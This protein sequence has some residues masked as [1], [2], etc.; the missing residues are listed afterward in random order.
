[1]VRL[2]ALYTGVSIKREP[3]FMQKKIWVDYLRVLA[4]FAVVT[5]HVTAFAYS[6]FDKIPIDDWWL[7]NLLN[8]LSRFS[9]PMFVM[10]SGYLIL[11]KS[12]TTKE[13]YIKRG[14]RIIPA[15]IFW[16]VFFVVFDF[17]FGDK[18]ISASI[19]QL[20]KDFI[21]N[22]DTYFHLWYLTMLICL[23]MFV[24][25]I[26]NYI[27]GKQPST[28]D[29]FYMIGVFALFMF[30]NQV[31]LIAKELF[32]INITWFKTFP[33]YVAYLVAGYFIGN[34]QEKINFSN[35]IAFVLLL[36]LLIISITLNYYSASHGIVKDWFVLSNTGIMNFTVTLLIFYLFVKNKKLFKSNKFISS[37]AAASFGIYLVH[38]VFITILINPIVNLVENLSV[39]ILILLTATFALSF[40]VIAILRKVSI[41]KNIC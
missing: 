40:L 14:F 8:G 22:G 25:F 38:P 34:Y 4:T 28:K 35:K 9:V 29:Y 39:A 31:S 23:M 41:F 27:L 36:S 17:F 2:N 26:N 12:I 1:V 19:R 10:I 3:S 32:D 15:L 5:I 11:G 33:W 24:P 18:T 7:A 6:G 30:L 37:I 16:S 21:I 20:T 13:F